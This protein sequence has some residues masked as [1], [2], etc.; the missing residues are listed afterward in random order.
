MKLV[1][2]LVVL[3]LAG[4]FAKSVQDL[5][6]ELLQAIREMIEDP[7]QGE[8][9]TIDPMLP[10]P[11][12][13]EEE[14]PPGEDNI[15]D[16]MPPSSEEEG[17]PPSEDNTIGPM[18]PNTEE[19]EEEETPSEDMGQEPLPAYPDGEESDAAEDMG[20]SLTDGEEEEEGDPP[21]KKTVQDLESELLH[22]IRQMIEDPETLQAGREVK[23]NKVQDV[24]MKVTYKGEESEEKVS[25][26]DVTGS[27]TILVSARSDMEEANIRHCFNEG[28]SLECFPGNSKCYL[29]S[30]ASEGE[31]DLQ[32]QKEDM[33]KFLEES[34]SGS[35]SAD[36]V[37]EVT[38]NWVE[39]EKV[40]R[41]DMPACLADFQPDFAVFS[42][43]KAP[44]D[45]GT[46]TDDRGDAG[47]GKR[48][49]SGGGGS[50]Q[51]ARGACPIRKQVQKQGNCYYS[52]YR[53]VCNY[54]STECVCCPEVT[55]ASQCLICRD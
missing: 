18:P 1:L 51:C 21:D 45:E 40:S 3:C 35:V 48:Y 6:S 17:A 36:D 42:A 34:P 27:E 31:P 50:Q 20:P 55:R 7:P 26:D 43:V 22:A 29:L 16:P 37:P 28:L 23:S 13:E 41:E 25:F 38:I 10:S 15:L 8:D 11:E 4:A 12:E 19:E 47:Q 30:I 39:K 52:C 32:Q 2:S 33:A 54:F 14:A 9:S 44:A 49:V 5:Q 24:T 53:W 46:V